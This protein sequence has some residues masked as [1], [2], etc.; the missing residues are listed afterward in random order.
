MSADTDHSAPEWDLRVPSADELRAYM[1]PVQLAFG[2]EASGPEMD[3]WRKVLEPERWLGAFEDT[4]S[5]QA[6]GGAAALSVR[7]TVPGRRCPRPP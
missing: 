1:E 7:L 4:Q 2:E 6:V 3:D 5:D